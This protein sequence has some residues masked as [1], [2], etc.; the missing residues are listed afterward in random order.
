MADYVA[1]L[2]EFCRFYFYGEMLSILAG[3]QTVI[4]GSFLW[5]LAAKH[6]VGGNLVGIRGKIHAIW[7]NWL[8]NLHHKDLWRAC[9]FENV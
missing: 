3:C 1:H 7:S 9:L 5:K 8:N 6:F 2:S 4:Y